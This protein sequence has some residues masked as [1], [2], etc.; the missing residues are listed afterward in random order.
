SAGMQRIR[1]QMTSIAESM[2]RLSEQSQ[3]IGEIVAAVED[4]SEQSN[5]LA[6]N[7]AIEAA[8]AKEHGKGFAVVADEIKH[9]ADQ[10]KEATKQVRTILRDIQKA[11]AAAVLATEEGTKSV[12][13]GV[14]QSAQ[15]GESI[16]ALVERIDE[17]AQAATQIA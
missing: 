16:V 17:A 8:T 15:A 3:T 9:L 10:S 1:N 11:T 12:E 2:M 4:L 5:L 6:V 13:A 14:A 7:A